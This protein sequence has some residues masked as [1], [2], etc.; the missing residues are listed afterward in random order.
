MFLVKE[1]AKFWIHSN[2][3]QIL[4]PRQ[5]TNSRLEFIDPRQH[6]KI[7]ATRP[8][9]LFDTPF[10]HPRDSHNPRNLADSLCC[11][12]NPKRISE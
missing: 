6:L 3:R 10:T 2:S 9:L 11:R 5:T 1:S 7:H 8:T 12:Q 4:D